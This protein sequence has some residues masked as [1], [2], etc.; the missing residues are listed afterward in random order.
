MQREVRHD[1]TDSGTWDSRKNLKLLN[2][3][4]VH[5]EAA[6]GQYDWA[7]ECESERF[8]EEGAATCW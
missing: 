8:P 3:F 6:R 1:E 7:D 4:S 2:I 5:L